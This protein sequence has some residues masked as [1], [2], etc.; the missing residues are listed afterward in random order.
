MRRIYR[1]DLKSLLLLGALALVACGGGSTPAP[2]AGTVTL[3]VKNYLAWCSV[4]VAGGTPSSAAVQTA[5]VDPGTIPLSAVALSGFELGSDPW[6]DTAGDTGSGDPGTV[7]GS[8]QSASSAT[9]VVVG[10]AAKCVWVCCPFSPGGNG[11]PTSDQC[12]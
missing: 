2:D 8:G 1:P 3:T 11:C 6:H 5:Q 10:S 12:P 7:T 4:T 9:T